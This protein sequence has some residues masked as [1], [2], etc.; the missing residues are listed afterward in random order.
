MSA[1]R[2]DE[3]PGFGFHERRARPRTSEARWRSP[4]MSEPGPG[5]ADRPRSAEEHDDGS[6]NGSEKASGDR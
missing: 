3:K 5:K 1:T 2:D 4:L 6:G